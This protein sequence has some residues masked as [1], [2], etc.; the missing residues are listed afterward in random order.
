MRN[1]SLAG[2]QSML[3]EET[4]SVW[5]F[6]LSIHPNPDDLD[7]DV[8][9]LC[10]D[11]VEHEFPAGSGT[12]YLPLPF[13]VTL[14]QDTEDSVPQARVRIDN[15]SAEMAALIRAADRP[16]VVQMR[17]F[18]IDPAGVMHLELGPSRFSLLSTTTNAFTVEGTLGYQSDFLNEPA[19]YTRFLP[20]VAPALFS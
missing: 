9:Y 19:S 11:M 2:L 14:A 10:S 6:G 3:A 7:E 8:A 1:V 17:V 4:A 5:L 13:E 18:R 20:V 16:P 12:I 15:V